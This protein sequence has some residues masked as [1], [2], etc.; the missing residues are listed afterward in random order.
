MDK[1]I[2]IF[3]VEHVYEEND[4]DEIKF[5]GVFSSRERAQDAVNKLVLKPGFKNFP[6]DCFKISEGELDRIGWVDGFTRW[7]EALKES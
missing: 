6:S 4:D 3:F 1:A 2:K 5:I 7:N